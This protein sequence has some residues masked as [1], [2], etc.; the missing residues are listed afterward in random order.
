M[1]GFDDFDLEVDSVVDLQVL[2]SDKPTQVGA[3]DKQCAL[4]S[5]GGP[6]VGSLFRAEASAATVADAWRR[7]LSHD[8]GKAGA[9]K[10][11]E[12]GV[13]DGRGAKG[14][15]FPVGT[16]AEPIDKRKPN[17]KAVTSKSG[18]ISDNDDDE[19]L[20]NLGK[21]SKIRP[22]VSPRQNIPAV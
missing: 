17:L 15:E 7:V 4:G 16:T 18:T 22:T 10:H 21:P 13:G 6:G 12:H 1:E 11:F 8:S 3:V 5:V 19:V 2:V 14:L 20:W 9:D